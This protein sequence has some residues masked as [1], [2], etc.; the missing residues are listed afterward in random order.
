LLAVG[1]RLLEVADVVG[2]AEVPMSTRPS[3]AIGPATPPTSA[4]EYAHNELSPPTDV[5]EN[6]ILTVSSSPARS[7]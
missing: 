4:A 1:E 5:D 7:A 2:W 6:V 3:P